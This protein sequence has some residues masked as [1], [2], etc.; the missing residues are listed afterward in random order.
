MRCKD[1]QGEAGLC[2]GSAPRKQRTLEIE[3][4]L[5]SLSIPLLIN[6]TFGKGR[7]NAAHQ[8]RL[9]PKPQR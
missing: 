4:K 6:A 9:E 5:T 2:A 1:R 3:S 7:S 8:R